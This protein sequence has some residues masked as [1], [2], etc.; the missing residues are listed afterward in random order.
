M[1]R[2]LKKRRSRRAVRA[3]VLGLLILFLCA[4]FASAAP[5]PGPRLA[6]VELIDSKGSERDEPTSSPFVA[7]TTFGPSGNAQRHLLKQRFEEGGFA[8]I[9]FYGSSW[10]GDGS[11]VAFVGISGKKQGIYVIDDGGSPHLVKG[12]RGGADP[13]IA[14]D[15]TTLVFSR[16]RTHLPKPTKH[17]VSGR[18]Y[19]STTT[20]AIGID[21]GKAR[22]L[23][24]RRN[25]LS[26]VPGSFSPDGSLLA[27]T[28]R[29]EHLGAPRIVLMRTDGGGTSELEVPGEEPRFAPDGKQLAFV[30]YL[31]PIRIE[32]EE[33]RDYDIG[34]LYT[35]NLDGTQVRRLTRNRDEIE[36]SPSWDPS[37]Q[38]LAYVAVKAD[39]SFDPGLALLF[40]TGNAIEQVNVDGSCRETVR[41][42]RKVALYGVAWQPGAER[43]AGRI[44]C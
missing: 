5:P 43:S 27:L 9:P 8:P 29:D 10:S 36:T 19:S 13:V 23:T 30:G 37:G 1:D 32:A 25:G 28:K 44:E 41:S 18:Y 21:G 39:T 7:V 4:Q 11:S 34:E 24:S 33:N 3:I 17:G 12:T 15:G 16:S 38:R 14:P 2:D 35:M 6:T 22:R 42:S 31:N 20:W 26:Y 40:P